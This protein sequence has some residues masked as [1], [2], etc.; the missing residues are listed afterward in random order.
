LHNGGLVL[1]EGAV[2]RDGLSA[3]LS[4]VD[5]AEMLELGRGLSVDVAATEILGWPSASFHAALQPATVALTVIGGQRL[6]RETT[7]RL[8]TAQAGLRVQGTYESVSSYLAS[9]SQESAVVLIDCD[10]DVDGG[11]R[12]VA[13]LISA[14]RQTRIAMLC[15]E[16]CE[17]VLRCAIEHRVG[18]V[19]LKSY[20]AGDIREAISYIASGRTVMPAGWQAVT[21]GHPTT[22][23]LSPRHRQIL[24]LIAAGRRN[25]EIADELGLSPN[26]IK[27]HVRALY[28]QLGVRNRV[29]AARSYAELTHGG[30]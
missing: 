23:T 2:T 27:F 20:S 9:A 5:D 16:L 30:G 1:D 26:T 24:G 15:Q 4:A 12:A 29:E 22:P 8:L 21:S 13:A 28:S 7:A 3:N 18:G 19:L 25:C 11:R 17:Q 6:V 14:G 10:A